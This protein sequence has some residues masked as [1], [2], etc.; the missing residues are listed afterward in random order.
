MNYTTWGS[1]RGGCG[2]L[3]RSVEAA[4]RCIARDARA[5]RRGNGRD[6]Y[7]DRAVYRVEARTA[8][9]LGS[10]GIPPGELAR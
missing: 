1:V 2:H 6:A 10:L 3:H 9:E 4:E 8:R 5:V 7:S